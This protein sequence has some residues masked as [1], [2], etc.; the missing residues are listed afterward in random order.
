[1]YASCLC[2]D[3]VTGKI[4]ATCAHEFTEPTPEGMGCWNC[5]AIEPQDNTAQVLEDFAACVE[6][7][8]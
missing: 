5:G 8:E 2:P 4:P 3:C 7:P 6:V 1:M